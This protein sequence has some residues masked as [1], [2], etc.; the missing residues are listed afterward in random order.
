[1]GL[2]FNP[3]TLALDIVLDIDIDGT[4]AGNSDVKVASQKATKTYADTKQSALGFTPENVANKATST[5]LGSS[6]TLYPSQNAVKSYVDASVA[7]L[8]VK[9][10]ATVATTAALATNVYNNGSSGVGATL[11]GFATGALTVDGHVVALNDIVLVKNEVTQAN[12][13]LYLCTVAGAIGVLYVLT[14]ATDMNTASE[15]SGAFIPVGAVGTTNSNSLW[16][17]NPATAVTVGTTAIP[18]TELNKATDLTAGTGINIAGNTISASAVPESSLS[19]TDLTTGNVTS[20]A[21]GFAQKSPGDTTKFHRGGATPDWA[22]PPYPVT[23]ALGRVGDVVAGNADY[24]AV[25][26]GG[27]T[28]AV[29]A[30]RFVGATAT[31]L[32]P[33]AGTFVTGDVVVTL[34]G[35]WIC[36]AGGTPGTW[37]PLGRCKVYDNT[38]GSDTATMDTGAIIPATGA[39]MEILYV[40]RTDESAVGSTVGL[41][42]NGDSGA[43]YDVV[44]LNNLNTTVTGN[45]ALAATTASMTCAGA[46]TTA[47][48]ASAV[49]TDIPAYA[50]TT[51]NKSG[52]M[53][54]GN[55]DQTAANAR[56]Q[57]K[58]FEWRNTAAINQATIVITSGA[59]QKFKTG[60]RLIVYVS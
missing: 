14:R 12:N 21:H 11:T 50:G 35:W 28:G 15:F 8:Q 6:D 20:T 5:A 34:G 26:V 22:V 59:S 29:T 39:S 60:S 40:C 47:G 7:G 10:T 46:S 23:S 16:L 1:M 57:S 49:A 45:T 42:L 3:F 41:R 53:V 19:I 24:L 44:T 52:V 18:F 30:T 13:G 33:V 4:L 9:S 51:F 2:K 32:P 43:N 38:L 36:T 58:A 56:Q 17:C 27:L 25:A 48:V 54:G 55:P 37:A 31:L